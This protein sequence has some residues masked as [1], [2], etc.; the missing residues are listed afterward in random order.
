MG[1]TSST[2]IVDSVI[3]FTQDSVRLQT[4]PTGGCNSVRETPKQ[5]HPT[6]RRVDSVRETPT[7]KHRTYRRV[8]R[9][10]LSVGW[11]ERLPRKNRTK[12]LRVQ[13]IPEPSKARVK[14][15]AVFHSKRCVCWVWLYLCISRCIGDLRFQS[16]EDRLSFLPLN[17]AETP[18]QKHLRD[19]LNAERYRKL[20]K[21]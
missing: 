20:S 7:Q 17:L 13:G 2:I 18:K 3:T 6:Y 14:P 5:K 1:F 9:K 8:C 12:P 11:V 21:L 16:Q 4:A 10:R 15:N 19:P